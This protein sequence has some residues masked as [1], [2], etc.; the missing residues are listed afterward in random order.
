MPVE[1]RLGRLPWHHTYK[2]FGLFDV[3][4]IARSL[5]LLTMPSRWQSASVTMLAGKCWIILEICYE[6]RCWRKRK[7][8][9]RSS[10]RRQKDKLKV[11]FYIEWRLDHFWVTKSLCKTF[12]KTRFETES[13]GNSEK[14]FCLVIY[15]IDSIQRV[16][17]Q[18]ARVFFFLS[19]V[20]WSHVRCTVRSI[21][22]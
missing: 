8:W 11:I 7:N 15:K 2:L 18:Q 13:K 14:A 20:T 21:V 10:W 3:L 6:H 4:R 5:T 12:R 9:S 19:A 17:M 16:L 22:I 1:W